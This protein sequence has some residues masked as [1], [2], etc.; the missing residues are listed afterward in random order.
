MQTKKT[1]LSGYQFETLIIN[2]YSYKVCLGGREG[3]SRDKNDEG[4]NQSF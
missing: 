3:D 2:V 4:D 1:L